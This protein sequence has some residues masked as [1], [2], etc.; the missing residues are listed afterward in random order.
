LASNI[1]RDA[2]F[3]AKIG[4]FG[5]ARLKMEDLVEKREVGLEVETGH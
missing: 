3:K 4:D 5:L 1:L 2:D